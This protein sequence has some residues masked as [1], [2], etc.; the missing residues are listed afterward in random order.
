MTS[1][2]RF[3]F[4]WF[5]YYVVAYSAPDWSTIL[6]Y[7]RRNCTTP[8]VLG[9]RRARSLLSMQA[10]LVESRASPPGWTGETLSTAIVEAEA[11]LPLPSTID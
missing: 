10:L 1:D 2:A 11:F 9:L 5:P 8:I 7:R 3:V 6:P 4:P